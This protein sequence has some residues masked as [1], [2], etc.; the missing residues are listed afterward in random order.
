MF[1]LL[2][3]LV[4]PLRKVWL[5]F[6]LIVQATD[7]RGNSSEATVIITVLR[8]ADDVIPIFQNLDPQDQ[9]YRYTI[10]FD[11][12]LDIPFFS[13]EARDANLQVSLILIG[14]DQPIW[15]WD[16]LSITCDNE[17]IVWV[18]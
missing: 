4:G 11:Q 1:G 3:E 16:S 13:V 12:D 17:I 2:F 18:S 6:Q 8:L 15:Q 7:E 5:Y 9:R 14:I 10:F